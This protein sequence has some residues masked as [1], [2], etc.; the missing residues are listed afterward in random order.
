[1]TNFCAYGID[2]ISPPIQD[3]NIDNIKHLFHELKTKQKIR[4][5][6]NIDMLIGFHPTQISSYDHL[7][8]MK[9]RFG[10]FLGHQLIKEDENIVQQNACHVIS[11]VTLEDFYSNEALGVRCVPQCGSCR[12]GE[13]PV[14]G[15]H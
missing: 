7:V 8:L 13:C 12:C 6:G 14:G 5:T 10:Y 1:M 9:N 3:I 4:P 15:K 2:Q 11:R